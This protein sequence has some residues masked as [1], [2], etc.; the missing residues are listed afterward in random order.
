[1]PQLSEPAGILLSNTSGTLHL[2]KGR[3]APQF[4]NLAEIN[5]CF[6]RHPYFAGLIF[7]EVW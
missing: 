1:M 6:N 3:I 5:A 2:F 4:I 7:Y